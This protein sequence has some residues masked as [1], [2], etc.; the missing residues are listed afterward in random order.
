MPAIN[1]VNSALAAP[2]RGNADVFHAL[3]GPPRIH[4]LALMAAILKSSDK[5]H[6]SIYRPVGDYAKV[7]RALFEAV[8]Q[9]EIN[10]PAG[11]REEE[12]CG[13]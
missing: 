5:D 3:V 10:S 9:N 1:T 2:Y 13:R 4:T 7:A 8:E 11:S 6:M 12:N